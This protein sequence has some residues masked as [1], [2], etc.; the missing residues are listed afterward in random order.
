VQLLNNFDADIHEEVHV[1]SDE[2]SRV[3][4]KEEFESGGEKSQCPGGR[5]WHRTRLSESSFAS[6]W[7][8]GVVLAN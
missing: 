1:R 3:A 4:T 7:G 8:W 2:E 5:C 6:N